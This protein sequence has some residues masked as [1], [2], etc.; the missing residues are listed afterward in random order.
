MALL[1]YLF[2]TAYVNFVQIKLETHL[3]SYHRNKT[4]L[5]HTLTLSTLIPKRNSCSC[6]GDPRK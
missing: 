5:L 6:Y 1:A 2:L 4:V 3:F